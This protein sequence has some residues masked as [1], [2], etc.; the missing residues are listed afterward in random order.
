M[1]DI[2]GKMPETKMKGNS[3]NEKAD[4]KPVSLLGSLQSV[5]T[6]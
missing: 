6:L 5:S 2:K 3:K 1:T 4:Q